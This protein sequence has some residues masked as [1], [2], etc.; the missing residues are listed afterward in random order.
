[1]KLYRLVIAL[2]LASLVTGCASSS[3]LVGTK[4]APISPDEVKIYIDPPAQFEKVAVLEASDVGANGFSAQSRTNKVMKRLKAEAANF[5]ANGVLL[6]GFH[7]EQT[8]SVGSGQAWGSRG[9]A[10]GTGFSAATYSKKG[11]G[12][13]I[14]VPPGGDVVPTVAPVAP[15]APQPSQPQPVQPQPREPDPAKRC[16]ACAQIKPF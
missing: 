8:G 16:D 5:G 11:E 6:Q 10:Y 12:I 14:Y 7:N 2:F 9:Y 4:R 15:P 3:V 1:M 13:A